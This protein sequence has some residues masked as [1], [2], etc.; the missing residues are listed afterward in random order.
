[1]RVFMEWVKQIFVTGI[2]TELILHLLPDKKYDK[3]VRLICGVILTMVCISPILSFFNNK[4]NIK[5]YINIF[6]K[7]GQKYDYQTMIGNMQGAD[8]SYYVQNYIEVN[9][10]Y[11][12][13][14][15]LEEGLNPV[16]CKIVLDMDENSETYGSIETITL[17]VTDGKNSCYEKNSVDCEKSERNHTR[18]RE[19]SVLR[20]TPKLH[21]CLPG[22]YY[23]AS[24]PDILAAQYLSGQLLPYR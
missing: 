10:K 4:N 3:Y 9:S 18:Q 22:R 16:D 15:V 20:M 24:F 8:Q 11:I 1:M 5:N 17:T 7:I 2:M 21:C 6:E 23:A 14:L 13:S 19:I 12:N